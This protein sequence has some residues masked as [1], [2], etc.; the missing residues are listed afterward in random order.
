MSN[1]D[2]IAALLLTLFYKYMRGL[3]TEGLVYTTVPPLYKVTYNNTS[4]YLK[5]D[6]ALKE[7]RKSHSGKNYVVDRFKG[8]EKLL[9]LKYFSLLSRGCAFMKAC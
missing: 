1:H 6:R 8:F 7:F 3:I 5:D 4:K 9:A 2:H